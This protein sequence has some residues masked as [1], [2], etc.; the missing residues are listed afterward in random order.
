MKRQILIAGMIISMMSLIIFFSS[1]GYAYITKYILDEFTYEDDNAAATTV[2][3]GTGTND[4]TTNFQNT[5]GNVDNGDISPAPPGMTPIAPDVLNLRIEDAQHNLVKDPTIGFRY[6]PNNFAGESGYFEVWFRSPDAPF[7]SDDLMGITLI[8]VGAPWNRTELN[9]LN[10]EGIWG[11]QLTEV[12]S[13]TPTEVAFQSIDP[14]SLLG[15][16]AYLGLKLEIDGASSTV[17]GYYS[18]DYNG[19]SPTW[20]ASDTD[21]DET[22]TTTL[23]NYG[24]TAY[25]AKVMV[26]FNPEPSTIIMF[27]PALLL[28]RKFTYKKIISR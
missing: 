11:V 20:Y 13:N 25:D 8:G 6:T 26:T 21:W 4:F 17:T 28:L 22:G 3:F 19:G 27:L 7:S 10:K 12:V 14:S 1:S 15:S 5:E 16:S 24:P 18:L 9:F 2:H 23:A